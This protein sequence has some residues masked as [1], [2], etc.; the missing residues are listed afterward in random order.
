MSI[1]VSGLRPKRRTSAARPSVREVCLVGVVSP[2]PAWAS[3]DRV[4]VS[5]RVYRVA[6]T[7][8]RGDEPGDTPRY[9]HLMAEAEGWQP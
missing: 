3:G 2:T 8:A 7:R 1:L 6:A 9:V 4:T 5:G